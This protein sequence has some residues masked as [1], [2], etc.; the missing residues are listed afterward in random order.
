M[1]SHSSEYDKIDLLESL[2]IPSLVTIISNKKQVVR[3]WVTSTVLL[4]YESTSS[5]FHLRHLS[6]LS[7]LSHAASSSSVLNLFDSSLWNSFCTSAFYNLS[8]SGC[9]VLFFFSIFSISVQ[10]LQC[11]GCDLTR[12]LLVGGHVHISTKRRTKL[13]FKSCSPNDLRIHRERESDTYLLRLLL[14]ASRAYLNKV[15]IGMR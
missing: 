8:R 14:F 12:H 3:N 4:K 7:T 11:A 1:I 15:E 9:W 13:S 5:S 10:L 2:S 6:M